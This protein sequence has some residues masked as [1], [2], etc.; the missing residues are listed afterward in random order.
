MNGIRRVRFRRDG[1][2]ETPVDGH[3]RDCPDGRWVF[4]NPR[5]G[6]DFMQWTCSCGHKCYDV[7]FVYADEEDQP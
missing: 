1:H 5:T 2:P 7:G 6:G 4:V 3:R